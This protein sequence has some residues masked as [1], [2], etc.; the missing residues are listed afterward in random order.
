[1][2]YPLRDPRTGHLCSSKVAEKDLP[3]QIDFICSIMQ[4]WKILLNGSNAKFWGKNMDL[5]HRIHTR[6][7]VGCWM[8]TVIKL[9]QINT[10]QS[11]K[12]PNTHKNQKLDITTEYTGLKFCFGEVQVRICTY[13]FWF[14][15]HYGRTEFR[16][17]YQKLVP[18]MLGFECYI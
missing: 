5:W 14:T 6:S 9:Y 1:M 2:Q 16:H 18:G 13:M 17:F 4:Y 15:S 8:L 3:I 7:N 12:M 10:R 11:A